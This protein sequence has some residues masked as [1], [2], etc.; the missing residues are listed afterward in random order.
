MSSADSAS[1]C[2]D[3]DDHYD[4][5]TLR[6]VEEIVNRLDHKRVDN[7]DDADVG[8]SLY[9]NVVMV[10]CDGEHKESLCEDYDSFQDIQFEIESA[11]QDFSALYFKDKEEAVKDL[12]YR[13][14]KTIYN[15]RYALQVVHPWGL[16]GREAM[17]DESSKVRYV[18]GATG[19]SDDDVIGT[20]KIAIVLAELEGLDAVRSV[21]FHGQGTSARAKYEKNMEMLADNFEIDLGDAL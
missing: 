21:G 10:F 16:E 3:T 12:S 13:G 1:L 6:N 2:I 18:A 14:S 19:D 9:S 11:F 7:W 5:S 4:D 17:W 20:A 8:I 15:I